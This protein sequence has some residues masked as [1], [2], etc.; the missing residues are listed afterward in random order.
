MYFGTC[1]LCLKFV[2]GDLKINKEKGRNV[3]LM[4]DTAV[5]I[6]TIE[7]VIP[8]LVFLY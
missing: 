8:T 2:E 6:L 3:D 1:E 4:R 5:D 7:H